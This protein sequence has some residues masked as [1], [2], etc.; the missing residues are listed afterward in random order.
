VT[1]TRL[2]EIDLWLADE[3]LKAGCFALFVRSKID[4]DVKSSRKRGIDEIACLKTIR[5]DTND[6]LRNHMFPFRQKNANTSFFMV[7]SDKR[8]SYDLRSLTSTLQEMLSDRATR[9]A[10]QLESL[11]L[12][13][14]EQE[15]KS[16]MGSFFGRKLY[17]AMYGFLPLPNLETALGASSVEE[18]MKDSKRRFRLDD[19]SLFGL[20]SVI[21][22]IK[23]SNETELKRAIKES[24]GDSLR[25]ETE[26]KHW[27]WFRK[28][29]KYVLP[30]VGS[31]L[32]ASKE[33]D[34]TEACI[35]EISN[36]LAKDLKELVQIRLSIL[37]Q[38]LSIKLN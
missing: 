12:E 14:I 3:S 29:S 9:L 13:M 20:A 4:H 26:D 11:A 33:V 21:Q 30:G 31:I 15:R 35:E 24:D 32:S 7:S 16:N 8:G 5:D 10:S 27:G 6:R 22:E 1:C 37:R 18:I 34:I 17:A 25:Q 36:L 2:N 19:E 38:D 28:Y 23:A